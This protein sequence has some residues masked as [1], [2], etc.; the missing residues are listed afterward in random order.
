[1]GA[2]NV[3]KM[4]AEIDKKTMKNE[5]TF[6]VS[7]FIDFGTKNDQILIQNEVF[8]M[9]FFVRIENRDVQKNI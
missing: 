9:F 8:L 3:L 1:M 2:Q 4:E 6:S 7:I 5:D